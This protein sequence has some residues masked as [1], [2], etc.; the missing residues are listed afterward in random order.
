MKTKKPKMKIRVNNRMRALGRMEPETNLIEINRK[1]HNGDKAELASS[2]AHEIM[3]VKHPK[4]TE[5]QVY[6]KTAKTKIPPA[7][8]RE[9]LKKLHRR[10]LNGRVGGLKRKFKMKKEDK[11]EP[12]TFINKVNSQKAKIAEELPR[13]PAERTA[14]MGAI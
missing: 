7:E 6:K 5:K 11:V 12:G 8:Q 3:H 1:A 14:I 10:T 4:M 2:V 9:L 13:I